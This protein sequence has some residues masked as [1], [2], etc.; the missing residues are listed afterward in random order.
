MNNDFLYYFLFFIYSS[1]LIFLFIKYLRWKTALQKTFYKKTNTSKF[2]III[3]VKFTVL[4]FVGLYFLHLYFL[5]YEIKSTFDEN[6]EVI[7]AIDVSG[8]MLANFQNSSRL[9][10]AKDLS[11]QVINNLNSPLSLVAFAGNA[12]IMLPFTN[13]KELLSKSIIGLNPNDFS[14]QGSNL[15]KVFEK[16]LSNFSRNENYKIIFIFSDGEIF[17]G[18]S[19]KYLDDI[20]KQG[21]RCCF[22]SIGSSKEEIVKS[23][24]YKHFDKDFTTKAN[25]ELFKELAIKSKS[26][27]YKVTEFSD[28]TQFQDKILSKIASSK[29]ISFE[30]NRLILIIILI[31]LFLIVK[32]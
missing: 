28:I 17:D 22:I 32:L 2:K 9:Q 16:S 24:V 13:D 14:F 20:K 5:G 3:A 31:L 23:N 7:V 19:E 1:V 29:E 10:A 21:I 11:Q 6:A 12:Y 15:E 26:L 4:F 8:S 27:H 30:Y 25:H 18:D